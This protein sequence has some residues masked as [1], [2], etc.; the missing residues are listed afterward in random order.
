[1]KIIQRSASVLIMSVLIVSVF[2]LLL[3]VTL[4]EFQLN[5]S[6]VRLNQD[7]S[8][9]L[10]YAAKSC[11]DETA[12]RMETEDDFTGASISFDNGL[13]CTSVVM[14]SQVDITVSVGDYQEIYRADFASNPINLINNYRLTDWQEL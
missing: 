12:Y 10:F 9:S 6:F 4:S 11:L 8:S 13:S 7:M 14:G 3:A 2:C 1:M 5:Q